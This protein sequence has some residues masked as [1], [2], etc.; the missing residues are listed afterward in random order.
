MTISSLGS[1]SHVSTL[2]RPHQDPLSVVHLDLIIVLALDDHVSLLIILATKDLRTQDMSCSGVSAL[3]GRGGPLVCLR[4][5]FL[6]CSLIEGVNELF[7]SGVQ[8]LAVMINLIDTWFS[9]HFFL[10]DDVK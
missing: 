7:C 1:L 8:K 9:F 3:S 6:S 4:C 2:A 10:A 5:L